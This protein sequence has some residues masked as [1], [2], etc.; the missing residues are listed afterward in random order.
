MTI[1]VVDVDRVK[2][3]ATTL[4]GQGGIEASADIVKLDAAVVIVQAA[5]LPLLVVDRDGAVDCVAVDAIAV[6]RPDS[7]NRL[8]LRQQSVAILR[9]RQAG[10]DPLNSPATSVV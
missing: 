7:G 10:K 4:V 8:V 6:Q 1:A 9:G 3:I 5:D 2:A